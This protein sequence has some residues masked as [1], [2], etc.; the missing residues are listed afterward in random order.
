ML[1]EFLETFKAVS[2]TIQCGGVITVDEICLTREYG[3]SCFYLT[4]LCNFSIVKHAAGND[5]YDS[6]ESA[7]DGFLVVLKKLF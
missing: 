2:V 1:G 6:N 3:L 5:Y 4:G 7:E